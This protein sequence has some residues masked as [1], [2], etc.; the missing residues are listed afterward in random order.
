V[1][2]RI[3]GFKEELVALTGALSRTLETAEGLK[4]Y[5]H[6]GLLR[7]RDLVDGITFEVARTAWQRRWLSPLHGVIALPSPFGGYVR[8]LLSVMFA[9]R[10][11]H[12]PGPH[13]RCLTTCTSATSASEP[14]TFA[15]HTSSRAGRNTLPCGDC[16]TLTLLL[17][18]AGTRTERTG[19]TQERKSR[20]EASGNGRRAGPQ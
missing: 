9:V 13:Q 1:A 16:R 15:Q 10:R 5:G 18:L 8:V 20:R 12:S 3:A 6:T 14:A 11:F 2:P 7:D 4:N 17:G 19:K